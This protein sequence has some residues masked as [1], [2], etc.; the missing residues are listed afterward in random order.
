MSATYRTPLHA[1]NL[2]VLLD[3][4]GSAGP[5][6]P[7]Y[8]L[9]THWAYRSMA[10]LEKRMRDL[11]LL[12]S[13]P[14]QAFL[15]DSDKAANRFGRSGVG[16]DHV[17]FMQRG[18]DILHLIPSPFPYGLWHTMNDD[19]EHLDLPTCRDWSRIVTAFVMEWFELDG[20]MPQLAGRPRADSETRSK[21]EL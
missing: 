16:D 3:L 11:K 8:F 6:V 13:R 20:Y 10:A 19:G 5:R 17:P 9:P 15:P 2:F 7:S 18:V 21:T 1:I 12:E 4:L 14:T